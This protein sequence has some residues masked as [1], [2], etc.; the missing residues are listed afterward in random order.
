MAA[1]SLSV[2]PCLRPF[3]PPSA[4][5][6]TEQ[7]LTKPSLCA[8]R[9]RFCFCFFLFPPSPFAAARAAACWWWP[10][11]RRGRFKTWGISVSRSS[12]SSP[13]SHPPH[14]TSPHRTRD[15]FTSTCVRLACHR[16]S[17]SSPPPPLHR[18]VQVSC[19]HVALTRTH[20]TQTPFPFSWL[21][22]PGSGLHG[23]GDTPLAAAGGYDR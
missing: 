10:R 17:P 12:S 19:A 8:A 3:F 22:A 18:R 21:R 1:S 14:R 16:V 13:A 4:A 11:A 7:P 15:S 23:S 20:Y 9:G 2:T 6:L 5:A